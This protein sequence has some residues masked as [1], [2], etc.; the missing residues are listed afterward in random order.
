[1]PPVLT[2]DVMLHRAAATAPATARRVTATFAWL[3]CFLGPAMGAPADT[4]L[5]ELRSYSTLHSIGIEWDLAG[6]ANHDATCNVQ[7]RAQGEAGWKPA[8][9]LFR[10]DYHGWYD[11]RKADRAYNMFA[12]SILFLHP[13]TTYEVQLDLADPDGG[14]AAKVIAIKTRPVP[15][16]PRGGRTLHV[17]PGTGGGDGSAEHPFMGPAAAQTA[18]KPGDIIRLHAGNYGTFAFDH[19]GEPGRPIV[20]I[21]AG[22]GEAVFA[23]ATITAGN[24]WLEGL[25][26][27]SL[28]GGNGLR[29]QG[30]VTDVVLCRCRFTGFHYSVFLSTSCRAWYV[31][32]NVIV[33]DNDAAKSD[34]SGEGIELN[35]SNDHVVCYNRISRTAD[36][37][38]YTGRNCDVFGNEIFDV[39]DDGIEPD[40][41]YANNRFWANRITNPHNAGL[42]FQPMY[43]G[44]WYFIRNQV[45]CS[46]Y[47][48][49]FRVQDRFVLVNNTFVAWKIP[50]PRM[51]HVLSSLSRNNLYISATGKNWAWMARRSAEAKHT[52]PDPVAFVPNWMTDVDYDGFDWGDTREAI[53]WD[54]TRF[55]DLGSF[56]NAIGIER[57]ARRVRK[58]EIF[59]HWNLPTTPAPA[60]LQHLT[61]RRGSN[62]ID[63]GAALP[64]IAGDFV[65]A[66][67]DLG[68]YEFGRP[69]PHYGPR[70]K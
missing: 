25:A 49:K 10:V 40:Y 68:A 50:D 51:H 3:L 55:D 59:E 2:D 12:G 13:D 24:V 46:G 37:V 19:P 69:L 67:P 6:D 28:G 42:S 47:V 54:K 17:T 29:A 35:H 1:M 63:A 4:H 36:G 31:A 5:G 66:A 26:F 43:C 34:I 16:L 61:L 7:Y 9:P 39:S 11:D 62:A 56:A 27:N 53:L 60:S 41:G 30:A 52:L 38:S 15:A 70:E 8:L 18:A 58:E 21:G 33:G 64:N 32:D 45:I 22:D 23:G 14:S 20:W 48:F 57:H 65:G 44:P